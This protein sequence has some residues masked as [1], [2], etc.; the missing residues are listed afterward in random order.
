M[1]N[2]G[3]IL[4]ADD[5]LSMR[6]LMGIVFENYFPN[7]AIEVFEN[8]TSLENRLTNGIENVR[9]VLTDNQMPGITGSEII[10]RYS[11]KEAFNGVPFVLY[12]AGDESIGK[13]LKE[14]GYASAYLLKPCGMKELADTL[15][16]VLNSSESKESSQ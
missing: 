11:Q 7:H 5:E 8:G 2:K 4:Y 10:R 13:S 6:K 14:E 16:R 1:E 15:E 12:Y 9:L 3:T